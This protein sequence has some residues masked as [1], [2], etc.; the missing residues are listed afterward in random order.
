MFRQS[1]L[2]DCEEI[3]E[4]ECA[5]RDAVPAEG[6]E[7]VL[8]DIVHQEFDDGKRHEERHRHA[9]EERHE[10]RACEREA[11]LQKF[12]R[13]HAE[14]H[15]HGEEK[16]KLRRRYAGHA[17]DERANDRRAGAGRAGDDGEHLK[18]TDAERRPVADVREG[19]DA[20]PARLVPAFHQDK[21]D[22]VNDE[23]PGDDDG[24][25]Q[26]RFNVIVKQKRDGRAGNA[27][28]DNLEPKRERILFPEGLRPVL[29]LEGQHLLEEQHHHRED[30]PE[31]D[32]DKKHLLERLARAELQKLV[33]KQHMAGA[34]DR[35]PFGDPFHD[36]KE[37]YL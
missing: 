13:A 4:H 29:H 8:T 24:R 35:Q 12:E 10:L 28:D 21:R 9:D 33:H 27:G 14:H 17:E 15:R 7:I 37:D 31:L 30:R 6:L 11:E 26:V 1:V 22:A 16:R 20:G 34:A 3:D 2:F 32:D 25:V 36:P 5:E 19:A 18:E 23:R